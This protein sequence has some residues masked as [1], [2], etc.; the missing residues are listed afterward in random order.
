MGHH[1]F[2]LY[3]QSFDYME[4][5]HG[6]DQYHLLCSLCTK[7]VLPVEALHLQADRSHQ[8]PHL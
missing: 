1:M 2:F 5:E 4:R 3:G 8:A 6:K 7:A